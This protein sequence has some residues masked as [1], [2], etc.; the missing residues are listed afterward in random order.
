MSAQLDE[1]A[2]QALG[3]LI[4]AQGIDTAPRHPAAGDR[5]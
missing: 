5:G 4:A 3:R 1:G 2:G